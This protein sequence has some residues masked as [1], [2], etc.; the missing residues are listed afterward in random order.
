MTGELYD[1]IGTTYSQTRRE[2]PRVAAQILR[3]LG[4]GESVINVGAGT[5]SYEPRDR[6]V[7]AVEPSQTMIDQR[8]GVSPH[9]VRA[10]AEHLP[11]GDG[12]FDAALGVFTLHHWTDRTAGLRELQRVARRQV[13][14]T[15]EPFEAHRF[16]AL[17]YF[18]T[19]RDLP[20]EKNAPTAEFIAEHL[21]VRDVEPVLV[22]ADCVDGFGA[23]FWARPERYLD[24]D[25]QEGMSWIAMLDD[26]D[27]ARATERLAADLASGEWESRFGHL[28]A[29]P[30]YDAGYRLVI[31]EN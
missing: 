20:T 1:L 23:A 10:G 16:W 28:R 19:A 7:V 8:A 13:L 4:P 30:T 29:S 27:R 12:F 22:P 24:R 21:K 17:E 9:V 15:F 3:A 18:D 6:F 5:G 26:D 14:L 25:V 2:D 31:A 11:F